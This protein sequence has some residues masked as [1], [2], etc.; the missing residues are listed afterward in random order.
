[1]NHVLPTVLVAAL[2]LL[3]YKSSLALTRRQHGHRGSVLS[4][5]AAIRS[6]KLVIDEGTW[7]C[8][9]WAAARLVVRG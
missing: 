4:K 1:M 3:C 5:A 9:R 7:R 8:M 6:R 2:V